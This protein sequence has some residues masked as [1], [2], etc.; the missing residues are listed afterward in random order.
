MADPE[1]QLLRMLVVPKQ[2]GGGQVPGCADGSVRVD[3]FYVG[4]A[5]HALAE[6]LVHFSLCAVVLVDNVHDLVKPV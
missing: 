4:Q 3:E 1:D 2:G 6:G 5:D